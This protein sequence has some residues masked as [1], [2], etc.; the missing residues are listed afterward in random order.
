M[1]LS[2]EG[3]SCG[4]HESARDTEQSAAE[5]TSVNSEAEHILGR[6]LHFQRRYSGDD[7]HNE[8]AYDVSAENHEQL[9]YFILP[10]ETGSTSIK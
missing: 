6:I 1:L 10:D 9:S 5:R 3:D 8:A 4:H 2:R 7:S